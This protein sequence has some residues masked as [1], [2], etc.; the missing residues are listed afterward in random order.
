[1]LFS[2][3]KTKSPKITRL[4]EIG[5]KGEGLARHFLKKQGMKYITCNYSKPCGEIDLIMQDKQT[6]VF[7]EVKTRS[8]ESFATGEQAIHTGKQRKLKE[9]A[10]AFI[11]ENRLS[12]TPYRFDAVIVTNH[13]S[14]HPDFRYY[15]SIIKR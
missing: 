10:K 14:T 6:L 1:M 13:E 7:V 9:T 2:F 4:K 3:F 12:N 15:Q 11:R 8:N 5:N